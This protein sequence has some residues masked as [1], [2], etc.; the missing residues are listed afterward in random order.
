M[1]N[2]RH[3]YRKLQTELSSWTHALIHLQLLLPTVGG[4][5]GEGGGCTA[6]G[7]GEQVRRL[8]GVALEGGGAEGR[9]CGRGECDGGGRG[10]GFGGS[11]S[12][13]VKVR[14]EDVQVLDEHFGQA[15]LESCLRHHEPIEI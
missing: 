8:G 4:S 5:A 6:P 13:F 11:G 1:G 9:G 2:S 14:K 10:R 3:K 7:G 12:G 15:A